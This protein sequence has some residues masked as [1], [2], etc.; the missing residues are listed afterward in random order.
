MRIYQNTD[1]RFMILRTFNLKKIWQTILH[2]S[3]EFPF[4]F[5][6]RDFLKNLYN[7]LDKEN[8][9][10]IVSCLEFNQEY[11]PEFILSYKSTILT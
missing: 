9:K 4:K 6:D 2:N 11:S 7:L 3:L 8:L 10:H 5:F 1:Y